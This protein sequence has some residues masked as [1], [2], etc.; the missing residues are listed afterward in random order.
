MTRACVLL[1]VLSLGLHAT[2]LCETGDRDLRDGIRFADLYNWHDA[3]PKFRNAQSEL[4]RCGNQSKVLLAKVGYLRSTME[5]RNLPELARELNR[6]LAA[7]PAD[8]RLRMW[9]YIVKGD[10]DNDLEFPALA[11]TDWES[12]VCRRLVQT[13]S[14]SGHCPRSPRNRLPS[15]CARRTGYVLNR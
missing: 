4:S 1:F 5:Q 7:A 8:L 11:K 3:E 9:I 12:T 13:G 6:L 2:G 10:I 14:G 15:E